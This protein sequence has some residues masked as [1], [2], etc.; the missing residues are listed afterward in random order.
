MSETIDKARAAIE[1]R[2]REL[3]HEEKRL[4]DAL[5]AL[6]GSA[7]KRDKAKSSG[8]RAPRGQR[9][10]QLLSSIQKNPNYK[11]ADH[12]KAIGVTPN[13]VYGLVSKLTKEK[14]VKKDK[15]GK[16]VVV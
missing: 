14:K 12:A 6:V 7:P 5:K 13:Q 10:K 2:L 3:K 11:A 15:D 16:L 9:E 4:E 8:K 1:D